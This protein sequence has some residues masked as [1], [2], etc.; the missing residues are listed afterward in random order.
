MLTACTGRTAEGLLSV[1]SVKELSA[2]MSSQLSH[3]K[4]ALD[5]SVEIAE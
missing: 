1:K 4:R 3:S 2:H 5:C